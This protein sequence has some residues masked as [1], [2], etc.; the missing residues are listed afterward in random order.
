MSLELVIGK[1]VRGLRKQTGFQV[2]ELADRV[3]MSRSY[4][5]EIENGHKI[6]SVALIGDLAKALEIEIAD[7]WYFIYRNLK[8]VE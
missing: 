7:V 2:K 3:P 6:P 5:S 1:T 4:L 8:D